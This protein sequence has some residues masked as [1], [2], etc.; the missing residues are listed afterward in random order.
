MRTRGDYRAST[1]DK[2]VSLWQYIVSMNEQPYSDLLEVLLDEVTA[3]ANQ[4]RQGR[5]RGDH[6]G[7]AST[8]EGRIL[9]VIRRHGNQSV[10]Q[11]ANTRSTSRQNIQII[12]NRLTRAG[13]VEL[14]ANPSHKRSPLVCLTDRGKAV[15]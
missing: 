14:R 3:L 6:S 13:C 9:Q 1:I 5:L 4:S 15:L 11:I 2:V 12:V 7:G 10:P 8:V